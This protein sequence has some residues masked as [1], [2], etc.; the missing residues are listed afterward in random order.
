[1]RPSAD[2]AGDAPGDAQGAMVERT[3]DE[4]STTFG[5]HDRRGFPRALKK[6]SDAA[7][8]DGRRPGCGCRVRPRRGQ[9]RC[10]RTVEVDR[11]LARNP[12]GA[13]RPPRSG[14]ASSER[15]RPIG[16][17]RRRRGRERTG[18]HSPCPRRG[19]PS[20][21]RRGTGG[22]GSQGGIVIPRR[23]W[24]R[25]WA[26]RRERP[27]LPATHGR[28]STSLGFDI[29]GVG[30]KETIRIGGHRVGS[31]PAAARRPVENADRRIGNAPT[32][33]ASGHHRRAADAAK[34]SV[35]G[36]FRGWAGPSSAAVRGRAAARGQ[37]RRTI[38]GP[39]LGGPRIALSARPGPRSTGP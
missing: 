1:M 7:A 11:E 23:A 32:P 33:G 21:R 31:D 26:R 6:R 10:P 3:A 29:E 9:N 13:A 17:R 19:L 15:G 5:A 14:D 25:L 18:P 36:H 37:S 4:G 8:R 22:P 39:L 35:P 28:T 20:A 16:T 30:M 38:R 34:P 27:R 2:S 12:D 24:A